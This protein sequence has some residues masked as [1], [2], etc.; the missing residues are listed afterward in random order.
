MTDVDAPC[1]M[2]HPELIVSVVFPCLNEAET[3]GACI[4]HAQ[5]ALAAHHIEGEILVADNGSSDGSQAICRVH[6]VRLIDVKRCGYGHALRAGIEASVGR[7]VVIA[8]CDGSYA[9]ED[10]PTVL[11]KLEAGYDL[12]V[13]NRFLGGIANGAM[14]WKNRYLGN[15]ALSTIGRMLFGSPIGDFQCGLRGFRRTAFNQMGLQSGGMEFATETIIKATRKGMRIAEIPTTLK[16]AGRSRAPHLR[17]WRDGLR[18]LRL[19]LSHAISDDNLSPLL[20]S[21]V[22]EKMGSPCPHAYAWRLSRVLCSVVGR[23]DGSAGL[24]VLLIG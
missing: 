4:R 14:P 24:S 9:L 22:G 15:P 3:L 8:D 21:V 23:D 2:E 12:V 10:I 17:P 16:Q 11:R 13:G 18:H 7:F 6:Q 20:C 5:A 1:N 19:M